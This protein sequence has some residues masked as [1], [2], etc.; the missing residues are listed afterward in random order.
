[1]PISFLNTTGTG[2]LSLINTNNNGSFSMTFAPTILTTNLQLHL[3]AGNPTSYPGSGTTWTDIAG[4]RNFALVNSPTYSTDNGGYISFVPASSQYATSSASLPNLS[5]WSVEVWHYYTS[6]T[7]GNPCIITE[8]YPGVT[9]NINYSL[10]SNSAAGLQSGFF[11]GSWRTTTA[12]SLTINNWYQIV[13]TYDGATIKLYVNN[14]LVQSTSY[15]GTPISSQGGIRLMRRW[16]LGNYWGGRLGVV[17]IYNADI[18]AA[19]VTQNWNAQKS[20]FGL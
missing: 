9:S 5:T 2:N 6:T 14:S 12:H 13:G 1:M 10:G 11:N 16:D 20:R 7:G 17:R 4:S 19:G 3:D 8:L 15:S 18:G